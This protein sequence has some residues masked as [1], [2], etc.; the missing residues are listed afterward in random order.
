MFAISLKATVRLAV[1]GVALGSLAVIVIM[2]IAYVRLDKAETRVGLAKNISINVSKFNLL[3]TELFVHR[4]DRVLRQWNRQHE[5]LLDELRSKQFDDEFYA[6]AAEVARRM[7]TLKHLIE[8]LESAG[9][10]APDIPGAEERRT[11]LFESVIA[12]TGV[13]LSRSLELR[14]RMEMTA[15]QTRQNI[16]LFIGGVFLL[17]MLGGGLVLL[18]ICKRLLSRILELR[19]VIQTIGN[20][21]LEAEIPTHA[22]D[23]MG[24]VF[25]QLDHMRLSL[26]NSIGELSRL[27]LELIA[28]KCELEDRVA[29]RTASLVAANQELEAFSYAVS[30]DLRA[31]LRRITGF[32]Q[33]ILE[34]NCDQLDEDG[35]AMLERVQHAT[36]Q[37]NQLIEDLLQLSKINNGLT[38]VSEADLSGIAQEI[39][40]NLKE[41]SP[42]RNVTLT[43]DGKIR[44]VCDP[45]M[46]CIVLTNLIENAWKFTAGKADARIEFGRCLTEGVE[47][48]FVR[49]NGAGFD[50]AFSEKLFKPFQR[51]HSVKD[52]PGTGIGL[53][54]VSRII[55]IHRGRTWAESRPGEGATFYFQ[56]GLK[57]ADG[58]D[59]HGRG[60][61][62]DEGSGAAPSRLL[63]GTG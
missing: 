44:A 22:H 10:R 12:Q 3:T 14:R 19:T 49:D 38:E 39:F 1:I 58:K 29:D 61:P 16:F 48:L 43:L 37:M 36:R 7:E 51:L 35:R 11:I 34:D 17:T 9:T 53:A 52:F 62:W 25:R 21:N 31:P 54:T 26:L 59:D 47:T 23:E 63:T 60:E 18:W 32:T 20:G 41:R 50:M 33:A 24:D 56:L 8:T 28:A 30:H 40:G 2:T 4:S 5:I 15:A 6:I 46:M 42:E 45:N 57:A 55:N 27:N 13:I